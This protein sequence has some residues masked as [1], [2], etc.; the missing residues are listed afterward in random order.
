MASLQL[1]GEAQA[2]SPAGLVAVM[3]G[4]GHVTLKDAL[5]PG[6]AT[7]AVAG[8]AD[9]VL[10][11]KLQNDPRVISAQLLAALE[12]AKVSFGDRSIEMKI[13]DGSVKLTRCPSPW[14]TASSTRR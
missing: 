4:S 13:V 11:G 14:P 2:Q 7:S 3:A 8:V 12:T 10:A 6:L 9:G 1:D 5:V